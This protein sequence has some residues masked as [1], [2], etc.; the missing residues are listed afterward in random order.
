MFKEKCVSSYQ[1]KFNHDLPL[2][3]QLIIQKGITCANLVMQ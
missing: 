2:Y 1:I 3:M